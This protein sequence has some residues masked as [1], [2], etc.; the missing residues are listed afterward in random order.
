MNIILV[1]IAICL[2][3][4]LTIVIMGFVI[5]FVVK[6]KQRA[7]NQVFLERNIEFEKR[8]SSLKKKGEKYEENIKKAGSITDIIDSTLNILQDDSYN[9]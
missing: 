3:E 6:A 2:V 7:E 4:L 5:S 1:L 9:N 8:K